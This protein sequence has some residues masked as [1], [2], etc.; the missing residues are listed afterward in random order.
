MPKLTAISLI[1]QAA[2]ETG[3]NNPSVISLQMEE[4]MWEELSKTHKYVSNSLVFTRLAKLGF[5]K[6]SNVEYMV[7][8]VL[9]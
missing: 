4:I 6:Y 2:K 8:R 1:K 9:G 3:S 7:K 5:Y